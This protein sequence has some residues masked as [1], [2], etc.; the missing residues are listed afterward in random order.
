[1]TKSKI[2][3]SPLGA[4]RLTADDSALVALHLIPR[5]RLPTVT[6]EAE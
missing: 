5:Q 6:G 1:M 3:P 2:V 4:I